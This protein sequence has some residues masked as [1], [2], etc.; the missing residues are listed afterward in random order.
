MKV[1]IVFSGKVGQRFLFTEVMNCHPLLEGSK[2]FEWLR[3]HMYAGKSEA[4]P[5]NTVVHCLGWCHVC[6]GQN[7]RIIPI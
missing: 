2:K 6:Q 4:F 5:E 7:S 1:V 3:M